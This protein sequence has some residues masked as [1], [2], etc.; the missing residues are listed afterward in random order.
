MRLLL[1]Y[2]PSSQLQV[3][4]RQVDH[5]HRGFFSIFS[6]CFY[7]FLSPLKRPRT[8]SR[9]WSWR[10]RWTAGLPRWCERLRHKH[11]HTQV[12]KHSAADSPLTTQRQKPC[13]HHRLCTVLSCSQHTGS[14][15]RHLFFFT[16]SLCPPPPPPPSPTNFITLSHWWLS[17]FDGVSTT[18]GKVTSELK[19]QSQTHPL[20]HCVSSLAFFFKSYTILCNLQPHKHIPSRV[21]WSEHPFLFFFVF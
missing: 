18:W 9:W 17:L 2:I 3:N 21:G 6:L 1:I 12:Q 20:L 5:L 15:S 10:R 19:R 4:K 7:V 14:S 13:L 8:C 11:A 16:C